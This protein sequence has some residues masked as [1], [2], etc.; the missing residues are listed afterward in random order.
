MTKT[1]RTISH[2]K[3]SAPPLEQ[4]RAIAAQT[5]AFL[6]GGGE[7]KQIPTGVSGQPKLGGPTYTAS[8]KA[9]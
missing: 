8:A 3:H 7:I 2:A 9:T 4:Q 6:A 1:T 5:A